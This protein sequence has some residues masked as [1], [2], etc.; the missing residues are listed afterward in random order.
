MQYPVV[1]FIKI[2]WWQGGALG[3]KASKLQEL[4]CVTKE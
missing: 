2:V 4:G 3:L 1:I